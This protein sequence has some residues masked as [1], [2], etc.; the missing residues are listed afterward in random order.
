MELRSEISRQICNFNVNPHR[1]SMENLLKTVYTSAFTP[2]MRSLKD[3]QHAG[4]RVIMMHR[5]AWPLVIAGV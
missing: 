4:W 3:D 1:V 5:K 2:Y